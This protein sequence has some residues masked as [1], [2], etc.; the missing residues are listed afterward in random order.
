MWITVFRFSFAVSQVELINDG[1]VTVELEAPPKQK[2]PPSVSEAS[3]A[4]TWRPYYRRGWVRSRWEEIVRCQQLG[5]LFMDAKMKDCISKRFHIWNAAEPRWTCSLLSL[6]KLL[7]SENQRGE[8]SLKRNVKR[9]VYFC[10]S[11]INFATNMLDM[12][13]TGPHTGQILCTLRYTLLAIH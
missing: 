10:F 9:F 12:T 3:E 13:F 5:S 7:A 8:M 2:S 6:K 4:A 11:E 1:P